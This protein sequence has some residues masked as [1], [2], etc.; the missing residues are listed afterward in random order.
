MSSEKGTRW[1]TSL[2]ILVMGCRWG[3]ILSPF[4][5]VILV[6]TFSMIVWVSPN[7]GLLLVN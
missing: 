4:R 2:R 6:I 5:I 7:S 3:I 1:R